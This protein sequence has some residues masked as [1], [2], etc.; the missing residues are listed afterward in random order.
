M[1]VREPKEVDREKIAETHN[2]SL[3]RFNTPHLLGR[4][5]KPLSAIMFMV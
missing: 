1:D 3:P 4:D 2:V 5:N